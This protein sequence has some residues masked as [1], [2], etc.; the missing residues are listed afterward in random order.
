MTSPLPLPSG[1]GRPG[2]APQPAFQ[3]LARTFWRGVTSTQGLGAAIEE[4]LRGF[5]RHIGA[6]RVSVWLHDR[7]D[8]SLQIVASSDLAYGGSGQRVAADDPDAP[9]ARGLRLDRP[10]ILRVTSDQGEDQADEPVLITPLRGWRRA[11][12][13]LVIEGT[14]ADEPNAFQR[15]ELAGDLGRQLSDGIE[16]VQ[17]L[18]E[19][20]R[21]RRLLEDTFN[22]LLDLVVVTDREHRVVQMNE[23]FAMRLGRPRTEILERPLAEFVGADVAEWAAASDADLAA[24]R[25]R[26]LDHPGLGGS[27]VVTMTPLINEDGEPVGTVLVARDVT[28]QTRLE[29]E[30]EALRVRLAQ[31]EKLA[32]LGQFVAG[33][34]HEINNPLQGVLGHLELL[35]VAPPAPGMSPASVRELRRNLRRIYRE[36]DRAAK[37]VQNLLT[38]SGSH[39]KIRRRVYVERVLTRALASRRRALTRAHI[40]IIRD[41]KDDSATVVGDPLLLQQTFL[42]VIINAEH[43]IAATGRPG[44]ITISTQSSDGRVITAVRD[45]GTGIADDVAPR[46][47]D[48]F[49]T[50]KA[51]G[52]GTG[53]G[54]A[55]TYGIVQ[56]PGGTIHAANHRDGGAVFTIELPAG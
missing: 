24:E 49:F 21:Q 4:V 10:Q 50:T 30:R 22:S 19:M 5:N 42:N 18:E 36:A 13:T 15:L 39:R 52:E 46:I 27:F 8:R 34:A 20:R 28:R 3:E 12:G 55:I 51:V 11:L 56:E 16:N 47:F 54:L 32:A 35:V 29:A 41:Q 40:D 17:L 26:A 53:L 7:R 1:A 45:S 6:R 48:P 44:T 9:A 2:P 43:A 14:R 33:I 23:A 38:F 31:S 25:V 37:I